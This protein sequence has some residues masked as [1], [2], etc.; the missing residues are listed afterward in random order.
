QRCIGRKETADSLDN[1]EHVQNIK[2]I[3]KFCL[4]M[5]KSRQYLSHGVCTLRFRFMHVFTF[6]HK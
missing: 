3:I 2:N 1:L 4:K 6:M 5:T